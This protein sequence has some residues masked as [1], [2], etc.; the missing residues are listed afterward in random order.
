M[1]KLFLWLR[2]LQKKKIV[3]LSFAAVALSVALLIVVASLFTGFI[4]AFERSAVEMVG[5]VV[6]SPP[7]RFSRYPLFIEQLE[8]INSVKKATAVLFGQGLLHLGKGDVRAVEIWGIEPAKRAE[9]MDFKRDL[10]RQKELP[11][12][13]SFEVRGQ[14]DKIG[15]FVGIGVLAEP[16]EKTDEY[17]FKEAEEMIGRQV[18]LTTGTVIENKEGQQGQF[19]RKTIEFTIA[20]IVYS[21]VYYSDKAFIYLP[22]GELQK[23]LCPNEE[24]QV[25]KQI[26]I[27]L[28]D[29]DNIDATLAQIRGLW[30]DF[31]SRQL[32]WD[33]YQIRSTGIETAKQMQSQ[34]IAEFRKQM[35]VLLLIFGI[36]SLSVVL[37]IFCIFYMIVMTRQKDIA[38]IKS[39]GAGSG[40]V[41]SIFIGFGACVGIIGSGTGAAAG[42]VI[43]KNIN[44]VEQ[45]IKIIFGL[46]L[47]KSSIYMFSK[48]PNE[49]DWGSARVIVILA[50]IAAI[51]GALIPAIVAAKTR[52]VE[53]LRYE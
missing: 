43:T 7:T 24:G 6:V 50:I 12:Q 49:V 5:D 21:G 46:K 47:W 30:E 52:P 13:P 18:V 37:L 10:L 38:I 39:C 20:D 17:D 25:A 3:F 4:N 2:Y 27:K 35:G 16:N 11:G 41:A 32:G 15:G 48:I 26:Q 51:V 33:L 29:S 8:R 42:Y 53:I 9:V 14:P 19:K 23:I 34:L 36:V 45:W 44:V 40:S 1:L 22:I 28:A 31:A